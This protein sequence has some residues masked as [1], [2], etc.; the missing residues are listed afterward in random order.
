[1]TTVRTRAVVS[2]GKVENVLKKVKWG[3]PEILLQDH[4]AVDSGCSSHMTG[5]KAYHSDYEI[6]LGGLYGFWMFNKEKIRD[7]T[8]EYILS[9]T[10][11]IRTRIPVKDVV[12]DAQEQPSKNVSPDKDIQ[13]SEDVF[14]KEG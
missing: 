5:N 12:Q 11:L 13:D 4:A 2:K 8:Q 1:M 9:T 3:N 7:H 10:N 14:D 6:Q